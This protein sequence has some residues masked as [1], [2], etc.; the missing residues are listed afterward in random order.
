MGRPKIGVAA[1][2]SICVASLA[3]VFAASLWACSSDS[4]KKTVESDSA[5][6]FTFFEIG[7][8][9]LLS[10]QIIERL[11]KRLGPEAVE[12]KSTIDLSIHFPN[13]LKSYFPHLEELN[14][15]LNWPPRERVEHNITKLIYRYAS[16]NKLPFLYVELFFS[17]YSGKPL[18]LRIKA[19]KSASEILDSLKSKYGPPSEIKWSEGGGKTLYWQMEKDIFTVS[20][21]NDRL[22]EP[23]YLFCIFHV[24]NLEELVQREK[25]VEGQAVKEKRDNTP[26]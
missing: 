26:F 6:G 15:R 17:D 20:L 18:F 9:S 7:S 25:V 1:C 22:G 11:K 4:S 10:D 21:S 13:F 5:E 23:E 16:Y 2:R 12:R 8:N 19:D 14:N 3:I 24:K